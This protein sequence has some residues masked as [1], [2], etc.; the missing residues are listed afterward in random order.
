[1]A[2]DEYF[3]VENASFPHIC[4]GPTW[5]TNRIRVG[6]SEARFEVGAS[7]CS[8]PCVFCWTAARPTSDDEFRRSLAYVDRRRAAALVL[9]CRERM[10][11]REIRIETDLLRSYS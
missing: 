8:E 2:T 3:L 9:Y 7:D 4:K 6:N 1:M 10:G 5:R 11:E